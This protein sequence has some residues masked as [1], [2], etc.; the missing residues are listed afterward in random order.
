MR[1]MPIWSAG[2]ITITQDSPKD[3]SYL[4]NLSNVTSEG[5]N[6]SGSS[7]KQ[8]HTAVAV[9]YFNMD[10]Q[11]I[12]YEVVE[13]STAQSKFGIITKQVKGFGCTSRGQAARLGRA[14][15]FAEQNE[16]E[17]V[18]FSTSIDAGAVVRPGAIIDI[19]D[20]VRAG[21]RRGGRLA[22]VTSTTVVT[23]DDTNATDFAVDSSGNPV[24]DAKLSLV[25]P[26]GTVEIKDITSVSGATITVSEAF[27]Q[28]PNVNTIWII[29]N[30]TIK[31]QKF[32]VITVEEQDGINYSI[33]ALSYVE[34]K[35]DFIEDG[36]AL[37]ARNI[38]ILNEL[39]EPPVGLTAQETIVPINNQAVSKI[40]IS[41]QPIVGVFEY[42][43]NYRYENGNFVSEKV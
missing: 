41:W 32:R 43:I 7:L 40:F 19:N 16:S 37:P 21:V 9:S 20:P 11:E 18:S 22:G 30:V 1:C 3:A 23:V 2:T 39:K 34:G 42:Q 8:R 24:G 26:D 33:T 4:F 28:T 31:S 27:S 13:D 17:L 29:S 10:S 38:S 15:L 12:D 25:L 35:Y 14:V 36:T 5:F 6:Y